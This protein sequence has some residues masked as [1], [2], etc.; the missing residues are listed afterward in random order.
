MGGVRGASR[1]EPGLD[2]GVCADAGGLEQVEEPDEEEDE[3]AESGVVVVIVVFP[4]AM[5]LVD[6]LWLLLFALCDLLLR[7]W[8]LYSVDTKESYN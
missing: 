2:C 3:S 7:G 5:S 8:Y 1:S 6:P 4:V